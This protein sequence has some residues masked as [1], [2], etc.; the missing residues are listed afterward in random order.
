[1]RPP[2]LARPIALGAAAF[3]TAGLLVLAGTTDATAQD[4]VA[5]L[6]TVTDRVLRILDDPALKGSAKVHERRDALRKAAEEIFDFEEMSRRTMG[7]HW[8]GLSDDQRR[9]FV[10]LFTELIEYSYMAKIELYSGEP[11]R[12]PGSRVDGDLATVSTRLI[13]KN[14]TEVPIDYR[15][16]KR[17]RWVVYDVSIEGVSLVNNYRTQFNSLMRSSSFADLT[18]K[19]QE[20]IEDLRKQS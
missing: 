8:R 18:R 15:M 20:R 4:A 16:V 3:L 7:P 13:T 1:M 6:R 11:I 9:Q 2:G 14:G 5:H 19:M 17:S 10:K 12:Y